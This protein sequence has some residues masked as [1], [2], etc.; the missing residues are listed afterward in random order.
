MPSVAQR[1]KAQQ[2]QQDTRM[3][4]D[5]PRLYHSVLSFNRKRY[6]NEDAI[7]THAGHGLGGC[8][9]GVPLAGSD[10]WTA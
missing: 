4:D 6:D 2:S 8:Y 9:S 10:D 3:S 7:R 1:T 5:L